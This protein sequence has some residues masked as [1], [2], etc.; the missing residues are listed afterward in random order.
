MVIEH[1]L[2]Q[3]LNFTAR[4]LAA[5][6]PRLDHPGVVEHHEVVASDEAREIAEG[7]VLQGTG[8]AVKMQQAVI[9][10]CSL[11]NKIQNSQRGRK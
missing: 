5:A 7:T 9:A 4:V 6:Q 2:D 8:P 10:F 3:H 1:A 11:S